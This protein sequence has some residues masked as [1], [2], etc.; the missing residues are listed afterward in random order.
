MDTGWFETKG[1]VLFDWAGIRR[2][3]LP[4]VSKALKKIELLSQEIS[5]AEE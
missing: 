1:W 2:S 5:V 4:S 3:S